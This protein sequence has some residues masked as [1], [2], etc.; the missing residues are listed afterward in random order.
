MELLA[1]TPD[2]QQIAVLS[3]EEVQYLQHREERESKLYRLLDLV[4]SLV[5]SA[6]K[7]KP[8]K[9]ATRPAKKKAK[10]KKKPTPKTKRAPAST[11]KAAIA[12]EAHGVPGPTS[13][14]EGIMQVLACSADPLSCEQI[15]ECLKQRGV[16]VSA[17]DP[18]KSIGI[19]IATSDEFTRAGTVPGTRKATYE[20]SKAGKEIMDTKLDG[21]D[22]LA[23]HEGLIK[24]ALKKVDKTLGKS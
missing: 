1:K 22:R 6:V 21:A 15:Y 7:P 14:R 20:L 10:A 16:V 9:P 19:N 24:R 2:G 17:K 3:T 11:T 8:P 18:V 13:I 5:P 23:F 4:Q 12:P